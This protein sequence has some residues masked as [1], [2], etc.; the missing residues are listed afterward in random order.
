M[1]EKEYELSFPEPP[2]YYKNKD[3]LIPPVPVTDYY[4]LFDQKYLVSYN[5]LI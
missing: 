2:K 4:Q 5:Y 3:M 1:E